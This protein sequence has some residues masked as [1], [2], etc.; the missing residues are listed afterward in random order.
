MDIKDHAEEARR[1]GWMAEEVIF[2]GSGHC[3]NFLRD[4]ERCA[5]AMKDIWLGTGK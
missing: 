2:E 4:G 3:A 1:K 5:K